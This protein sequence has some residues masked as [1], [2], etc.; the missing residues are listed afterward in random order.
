MSTKLSGPRWRPK[1]LFTAAG[2]ALCLDGFCHTCVGLGSSRWSERAS[3][4][5]LFPFHPY[6]SSRP[7]PCPP[8]TLLPPSLSALLS[9]P[10]HTCTICAPSRPP[11]AIS[12]LPYR[13]VPQSCL[14]L[15]LIPS[16]PPSF[17]RPLS[18]FAGNTERLIHA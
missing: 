3:S 1:R 10:P 2:S 15:P 17:L 13:T 4:M 14:L 11:S 8:S 9:S 18:V 7:R 5:T 12:H 16:C 6:V